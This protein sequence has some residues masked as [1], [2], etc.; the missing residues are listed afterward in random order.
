MKPF[1]VHCEYSARYR[2]EITVEAEHPIAACRA[3][4]NEANGSSDWRSHDAD[5]PSYVVALA[6]GV[7]VDPWR[8]D[9]EAGDASVLPVPGLFTDTARVAGY[10]ATRSEDLVLQLRLM[11]DAIGH[12]GRL[13]IEPKAMVRL[14]ATGNAMLADVDGFGLPPEAMRHGRGGSASPTVSSGAG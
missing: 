11:L 4:V 2:F 14:C 13:R 7:D 5:T 1:T 3:A 10:A 6:P 9:P 12:D 8:P